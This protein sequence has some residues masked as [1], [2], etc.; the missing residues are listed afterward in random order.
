[1][2]PIEDLT[3]EQAAAELD[4]IL[5]TIQSQSC[6]IDRLTELTRRASALLAACRQRLTATEAELREILDQMQ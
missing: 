5:Q 2:T 3:Y 1:M 6:G 4:S